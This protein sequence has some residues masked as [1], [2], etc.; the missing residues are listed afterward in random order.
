MSKAS[1]L[2]R[3]E[4]FKADGNRAFKARD[5][6]GALQLYS[7]GL[8]QLDVDDDA[9][10]DEG[11][12]SCPGPDE[13]R[14]EQEAA[15][16]CT[17]LTNRSNALYS[18]GRLE[19]SVRDAD[20]VLAL[21]PQSNK[22]LYRRGVGLAALGR[23]DDAMSTYRDALRLEGVDESFFRP[24]LRKLEIRK[25]KA[26]AQAARRS[27]WPALYPEQPAVPASA[28]D[29]ARLAAQRS[30]DRIREKLKLGVSGGSSSSSSGGDDGALLDG[31]FGKLLKPESFRQ[32][33]YHSKDVPAGMA[34][35][36]PESFQQLLANQ[37]YVDALVALFPKIHAKADS[38]LGNVKRKAAKEGQVMDEQT[39]RML[40]P[41]VL[42][43]A[44]AHQIVDMIH[45][46][47]RKRNAILAQKANNVASADAPEAGFDQLPEACVAALC[48]DASR[49]GVANG[50]LDDGDGEWQDLLCA[51]V[52]DLVASGRLEPRDVA[53]ASKRDLLGPPP[54]LDAYTGCWT[55]W[56]KLDEL[57]D[58]YSALHELISRMHALPFEL[59]A[60]CPALALCKPSASS[61]LLTVLG[62]LPSR[63]YGDAVADFK[64]L[65]QRLDGSLGED[66]NGFKVSAVYTFRGAEPPQPAE[67]GG[68]LL[69]NGTP[70]APTTD[71]L[72]LYR[73]RSVNN[74]VADLRGPCPPRITV[75]VF[76]NGPS[77]GKSW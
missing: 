71:S 67:R 21:L 23:T 40:R 27:N 47:N 60:K 53:S 63:A 55:C 70:L 22:A 72:T 1:V 49:F 66:N 46:V 76:F 13:A 50:F 30:I 18:L 57:E 9:A 15:L 16:R 61:V 74:S 33:V 10:I 17:L 28:E 77:D 34:A 38:V 59:N 24:L 43:E 4:A 35:Y 2:A 42:N 73:S 69:L 75:S 25:A 64:G 54:D 14:L 12:G 45:D 39:E 65:P 11:S 48:D 68:Q 58:E 6:A 41:Q 36:M 8:K 31:L 29:K 5:F 3:A 19:E 7:S 20:A 51:D 62:P 56:L 32:I 26:K 44:F 37:D 52:E